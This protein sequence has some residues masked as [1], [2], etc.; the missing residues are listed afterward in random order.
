M[1]S[2]VNNENWASKQRV[3]TAAAKRKAER[4]SRR[5]S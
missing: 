1:A 5:A 4:A 2:K 3:K